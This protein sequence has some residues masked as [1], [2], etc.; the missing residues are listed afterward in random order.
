M[1]KLYHNQIGDRA[2]IENSSSDILF[3]TSV[4]SPNDDT[5]KNTLWGAIARREIDANNYAVACLLEED[6]KANDLEIEPNC[7]YL[8]QLKK[9]GKLK[10]LYQIGKQGL[11]GSKGEDAVA[12]IPPSGDKGDPADI[13]LTHSGARPV[14]ETSMNLNRQYS[15]SMNGCQQWIENASTAGCSVY[16]KRI[17]RHGGVEETY[18]PGGVL[19]FAHNLKEP[20]YMGSAGGIIYLHP[21]S[22][23]YTNL[24]ATDYRVL[25]GPTIM[26]G[27]T[28]NG[29]KYY[30]KV[31]ITPTGSD[32]LT[33]GYYLQENYNTTTDEL[34]SKHETYYL[35]Q[36]KGNNNYTQL[37]QLG[38][39]S[40]FYS[41]QENCWY[42]YV[43]SSTLMDGALGSGISSKRL[44]S[45]YKMKAIHNPPESTSSDT[46]VGYEEVLDTQGIISLT[47]GQGANGGMGNAFLAGISQYE[48][49]VD[50][51]LECI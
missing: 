31:S 43:S 10:A 51:P 41:T 47:G 44:F 37:L 32:Q 25:S 19:S 22:K 49:V 11:P 5:T 1:E 23:L 12:I 46:I 18:Y 24:N 17:A 13:T 40:Y 14:R 16:K 48:I 6:K 34:T 20:N 33:L 29:D 15:G 28:Y 2:L 45:T 8:F 3:F 26:F 38:E 7:Y 21:N 42:G 30:R 27:M 50:N 35:L 9:D 39:Y 36:N 4:G